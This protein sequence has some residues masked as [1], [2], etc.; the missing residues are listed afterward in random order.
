MRLSRLLAPR[1]A[2]LLG[3]GFLFLGCSSSSTPSTE[4]SEA[5]ARFNRGIALL[6]QY[7]YDEAVAEFRKVLKFAPDW[8]AARFNLGVAY[9]NMHG[10]EKALE[11]L[12]KGR[13]ELEAV[14]KEQPGHLHAH[15]ALGLLHEHLGENEK[16]LAHYETVYKKDNG[17]PYVAYKYAE[18]LLGLG[19]KDEGRAVLERVVELDP[20]FVSGLYQLALQYQRSRQTKKAAELF[21]RFQVISDREL[22]GGTFVVQKPYGTVGKYYRALGVDSLPLPRREPPPPRIVLSPQVT[23]LSMPAKAWTWAGGSVDVAGVAVGDVD[24][25][26]DLDLC[27]TGL[28]TAGDGMVWTNSGAGIF[29]PGTTLATR[30]VSPCFGD[31]DNDG[32]L[33]LWLGRAG[34]DQ[35]FHNDGKGALTPA[36]VPTLAGADVLTPCARLMD[37]DSDGDLD[38]MA[39]RLARGS[40]PGK[41]GVAA[42]SSLFQNNRDGTYRDVASELKL[43]PALGALSTTLYDDIDDDRDLDIILFPA[44]AGEAVI[45]AN[46]R[47]WRYRRVDATA[48]GL[49]QTGVVG[50]TSGDPDRD[51]DRDLLLFTGDRVHLLINRGRFRFEAHT[52]F[53]NRCGPLGGTGGQ[54]ADMDNDGDLD[55]VI[56]DATRRGGTRGPAILVNDW[57]RDRFLDVT[58]TDPGNLVYALRTDGPASCVAADF[59]GNGRC[60]ILVVPMG[61]PPFLMENVTPGGHWIAID[62]LGTRGTD[63]KTRSNNS[64]IGARVEIKTGSVLQQHVVGTPS[65]PVAMPPFRIHAGLGEKATV[66]WLRISWPDAVMQAELELPADRVMRIEEIQ[67]KTSS[68]PLLFAWNGSRFSFVADFGGVGGLGYLVAPDT[69]APS[70]PTE[71][72]R[73]PHLEPRGDEYLLNV[74]GQLEEVVYLDEAK[75]I[76]VDHAEGTEVYPNE[77]MAVGTTPPSF[78]VFC[79]ER[80]IDCTRAVD[81]RGMDVT[82]Q[83][84][85][86]D[87][88]YAGATDPDHRFLGLSEKHWVELDFGDRL[89]AVRADARLI[90]FLYGWVEYGYSSTNFA[91]S[92]AGLCAK[93]PTIQVKR[94]GVWVELFNEVGY[95]A[96]I[97]HMMTLEVSGTI[98]PSDRHIR[99]SSSMELYWDRIFLAEH[100]SDRTRAIKELPLAAADLHFHGYPREYSPDGKHPNVYDYDNVDRTVGWKLMGGSYT[101]YGDVTELLATADDCYVIMGHGEE[102]TFHFPVHALGPVPA[103]CSRTFILKTDSFCKDM[104]LYTAHPETV[105]P[106]PFHAMSGYP[107]GPDEGYPDDPAHRAYQRRFNTRRVVTQ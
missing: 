13:N 32:D 52:P 42:A 96:G 27:L 84:L 71:Y 100:R 101:C 20:G 25:D 104:D 60:D 6:E 75:L 22:A 63:Q 34:T 35:L 17:D 4:L 78:E 37:A 107:Y 81:H 19:R 53:A 76:A 67:R 28:G 40:V 82:E 30:A 62:L 8:T 105:G 49:T 87:R 59:T 26:G 48:A 44:G 15:F 11:H 56:A 85:R 33:D 47:A 24:G 92:Q 36:A 51:G 46:D 16:A 64:A 72:L 7:R 43:E 106:L 2:I 93:A 88:Q 68:C 79:Y 5:L 86:I 91:A 18:T 69:Y 9:F 31:V 80:P 41:D 50:A 90:L 70:D 97:N 95:P 74:L 12:E 23:K 14:L 77:M 10:T 3:M 103:G 38:L 73:I 83:L 21:K 99:I 1:R 55:I 57:P 45:L 61:A 66:D 29:S 102:V 58:E 94:N 39:L 89:A 54:F 98:L 65:G